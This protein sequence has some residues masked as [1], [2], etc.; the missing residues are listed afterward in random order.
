[1]QTQ[2]RR[3]VIFFNTTLEGLQAR[4]IN[5]IMWQAVPNINNTLCKKCSPCSTAGMWFE[6]FYRAMH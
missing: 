4:K 3:K 2:K 6:Y 5:A 1:M